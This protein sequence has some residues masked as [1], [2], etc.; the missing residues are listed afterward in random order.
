VK[1]DSKF[2]KFYL[3]TAVLSLA[4]V[5]LLTWG[6]INTQRDEF[7]N[8]IT[9][10]LQAQRDL[11]EN[12]LHTTL[13]TL[14]QIASIY[15]G[16]ER[17]QELFRQG[18]EAVEREG[19]GAGGV[20]AARIRAE[21]FDLVGDNWQ[22]IAREYD[23]RQLQFH[24]PPG[25]TSFLRIHRPEKFGDNMDTVRHT[26]VYS[27]QT[28]TKVRS[29]EIGRVVSGLRGVVPVFATDPMSGEK[30]HVGALEAG[31]SF[32]P[33]MRVLHRNYIVEGHAHT[34]YSMALLDEAILKQKVWPEFLEKLHNSSFFIDGHFIESSATPAS[35]RN[36]LLTPGVSEVI[37]IPGIYIFKNLPVPMA[38]ISIPLHDFETKRAVMG[39]KGVGHIIIWFD[40]SAGVRE[41]T[42]S[43]QKS[44]GLAIITELSILF[45]AFFVLRNLTSHLQGVVKL[46][47]SLREKITEVNTQRNALKVSESRFRNIVE[48]STDWI[49]ETDTEG[50]Y[51]YAS[52]SI[53]NILGYT[54]DEMVGKTAFDF[55]VP[56]EAERVKK[57][58]NVSI[59]N[60]QAIHELENRNLHKNG[61]KIVLLTTAVPILSR[62]GE[63]TGYRG[64]DRDITAWKATEKMRQARDAAELAN[65]AK[66]EFLANMSHE[67]RTP[68]HGILSYAN[69]GIK[70]LNKVPS[71]KILEY[72]QEI[73]DSGDRLM[74]LLNDLLD[75]AKME[76]GKMSYTMREQDLEEIVSLIVHE[77]SAAIEEKG[78]TLRVHIRDQPLPSVFDSERIVQVLRN[79]LSNAIKF[80][81]QG[82]EIS[83]DAD[84]ETIMLGGK[85]QEVVMIAVSDQGIGI[86]EEELETVF[87]KFIQSS[88]TKTGAGG[89]GLGLAICKQIMD[90]HEGAKIWAEQNPGGGSI[91]TMRLLKAVQ[92]SHD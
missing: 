30:H 26:I 11:Y 14:E 48:T 66:S 54:A 53:E 89:T 65:K 17:V 8:S 88:S 35:A 6:T 32:L 39:R 90:D 72:F 20:D 86:P 51:I 44:V 76:S 81:K 21:L 41:L 63:L 56:E 79:L 58:F 57:L 43:I 55:M 73:A 59:K 50:T 9:Q 75:L 80:T 69:F 82:K 23:S 31:M 45:F 12:N 15:A 5:I 13:E 18:R 92:V 24:L 47:S 36:L 37:D 3:L 29:F 60:K 91:F 70:R 85:E 68:M 83:I 25:S 78:L 34:L 77:F 22:E 62:E 16:D 27:N 87:D 42:D 74:L 19:G 71:E 1:K 38:L 40:I 61:N 52:P 4:G 2:M 33:I 67:L 64:I 28:L 10:V 49:W 84:T 7:K 46:N